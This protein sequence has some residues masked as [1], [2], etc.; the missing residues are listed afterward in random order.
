[1]KKLLLLL[2]FAIGTATLSC[3]KTDIGATDDKRP[4][5]PAPECPSPEEWEGNWACDFL[6]WKNN[7][8]YAPQAV[9]GL[10]L[11]EFKEGNLR[12][13][14]EA[15]SLQRPKFRNTDRTGAGHYRWR[16]YV[17][18]MGMNEKVSIGAFLYCDDT[19][20]LDFEIGS[21]TA[22]KRK[23]YGA[24]EDEVLMYLTSQGN[25]WHQSIHPI[26]AGRWYDLGM[27][28][29]LV[30]KHHYSLTWTLNGQEIDTVVLDFGKRIKFYTFCSLENLHFMGDKT[31]T[32]EHYVLFNK[33][34]FS[35]SK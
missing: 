8:E 2:I 9:D 31:S 18:E 35:K 32:R 7:W 19:H 23:E 25:P 1:M 20:E 6:S 22:Q 29:T 34:G 27:I 33:V 16:V 4:A 3:A 26:K 12:L 14:T 28:L 5:P 13:W 21:G 11:Y 15:G 30:D 10:H 24:K 17:P